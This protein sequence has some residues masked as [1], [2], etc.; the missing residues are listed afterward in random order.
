MGEMTMIYLF[1][2]IY[3]ALG[4]VA[5]HWSASML[6]VTRANFRTHIDAPGPVLAFLFCPLAIVVLLFF[7]VLPR[8]K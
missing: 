1:I 5:A 2:A 3:I 4:L 7:A 6:G 8:G